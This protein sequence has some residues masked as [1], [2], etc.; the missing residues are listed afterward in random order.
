MRNTPAMTIKPYVALLGLTLTVGVAHAL[1]ETGVGAVIEQA[2][3]G[4]RILIVERDIHR[5]EEVFVVQFRHGGENVLAKISLDGHF[6]KVR[7]QN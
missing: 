1:D 6:V 2:Y 3:P 7:A 4:A 5:G